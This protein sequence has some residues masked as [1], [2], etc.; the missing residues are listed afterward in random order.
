MNENLRNDIAAFRFGL[1][2]Q[3]VQRK[4]QPGERYALLCFF[5]SKNTE[6]CN[7]ECRELQ[8]DMEPLWA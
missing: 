8:L 7:G 6:F 2:A 5:Q 3:V 1:I 4:L